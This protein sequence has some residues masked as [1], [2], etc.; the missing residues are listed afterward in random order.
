MA[1]I[2]PQSNF[3]L[4]SGVQWNKSYKDTRYFTSQAQQLAYFAG[5]TKYT[6]NDFTYIR[7]TGAVSVPVNAEN[8]F[9]CNYC[10]FQNTAYGS[11]WFYAFITGIEYVNNDTAVVAFEIDLLQTW[12]FDFSLGTCYVEREHVGDDTIGKHTLNENL[13]TGEYISESLGQYMVITPEIVLNV[14][15]TAS[16]GQ[17]INNVYSPTKAYHASD[18]PTMNALLTAYDTTPEKIASLTMAFPE[19]DTDFTLTDSYTFSGYT[20]KNNKLY[21]YPYN[22][23]TVGD[24]GANQQ[25]YHYEDFSDVTSIIFRI[26]CGNGANTGSPYAMAT[27]RQYKGIALNSDFALCKT[28]FPSCAYSIDNF[29]A[30]QAFQGQQAKNNLQTM[31]ENTA[32]ANESAYVNS[33]VSGAS[34]LVGGVMSGSYSGIISGGVSATM[35]QYNTQKQFE[36]TLNTIQ[37][38]SNNFALDREYHAVHG[39]SM[40]G[41]LGSATALWQQDYS[42]GFL[43]KQ[44]RVRNEYAKIID[45]FFT[46]FGYK[47]LEAKVPN[48]TTRANFN[49]LKTIEC[50]V[51]GNIPNYA[52]EGIQSIFNAGVTLWHNDNVGDYSNNPIV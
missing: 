18:A 27:P 22:F 45:D 3:K 5:K 11:K 43:F 21:C 47:V 35:S 30:W 46:R 24:F 16:N 29:R 36:Q 25:V 14:L 32:I 8:I 48:V 20:P 38:A 41:T 13:P 51:H 49:Y 17:I 10:A 23:F 2:V 31:I 6:F 39:V 44:H 40:G 19:A 37:N 26:R 28:D 15:E 1:Y 9:D 34:A 12:L 33:L 4:I 50:E 52:N 42:R 7:Q